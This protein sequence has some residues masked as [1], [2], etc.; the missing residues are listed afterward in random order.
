MK[1]NQPVKVSVFKGEYMKQEWH[2]Q[3]FT[4]IKH[5]MES[6]SPLSLSTKN[7]TVKTMQ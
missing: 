7:L 4:L 1:A 6:D 5:Q 3:S 2:C